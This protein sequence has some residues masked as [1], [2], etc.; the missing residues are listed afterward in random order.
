MTDKN[1]YQ[2]Q[3]NNIP[4]GHLVVGHLT[5]LKMIDENGEDYWGL[6]TAGLNLMEGIGCAT[7]M[8][9]E[10]KNAVQRRSI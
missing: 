4:A 2:L 7:D 5:Y 6:R 8:L 9:E 3:I 10:A 1:T